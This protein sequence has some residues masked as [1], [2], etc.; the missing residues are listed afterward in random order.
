V[1]PDERALTPGIASE[2][3]DPAYRASRAEAFLDTVSRHA[4][5][6][7]LEFDATGACVGV[8][9]R[10]AEITGGRPGEAL[11]A[12]WLVCIHEADRAA[13]REA[14]ASA[15]RGGG[16]Q[17]LEVRTSGPGAAAV[18]AAHVVRLG[19]GGVALWALDVTSQREALDY[20]LRAESL[21]DLARSSEVIEPGEGLLRLLQN[22][23]ERARELTGARYAAISTFDDEGILERFIYTGISDDVAR[24]LGRPPIGRGLLGILARHDRPIR[25]ARLQEHESFTGWPEGHPP[26]AAFL[27]VPI[28][29]GGRTI[30]SLYVTRLA[31][32]PDFS[33]TDEF[34]ATLLASQV[35]LSVSAAMAQERRGRVTLLEERVRI[36]HDLH[37][38]TIQSL[39]ALGLEFDMARLQE[40]VPAELR[41][42]LDSAVERING[43]IA[44][45][46]QYIQMLEASTPTAVPDLARD[47]PHVLRQLVP[48]GIDTVFN[49][50]APALQ[51]LSARA[52]EDFLF[53]AREALSNA[54]RHGQ[55]TKIAVDFRQSD[56]ETALTIQDNGAGFDPAT[57]R[58]GLG[59]TTM[60]TRAERLGARLTLLGIPGM[61]ATV[62][63]ALPR[64]PS[65]V[66]GDY[67]DTGF[68]A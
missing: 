10:W 14:V 48:P 54:V 1:A 53:I 9:E 39:Y 13:A 29:A 41:A 26:M 62:R 63:V 25:L 15:I 18:L 42:L 6:A 28:R 66:D 44:D 61:G 20:A 23:T 58:R 46:R 68:I 59:S 22:T 45:I 33:D 57:V 34:A 21:I 50:T 55:P 4:P 65:M 37:D 60:H 5:A 11:G 2:D 52:V 47:L 17:R 24:R 56:T 64:T 49:I 38:G 35:A 36:A 3:L 43:V 27:G 51:E 16:E 12:G 67:D 31:G 30:G 8:S 32:D 40:D 7:I 19:H